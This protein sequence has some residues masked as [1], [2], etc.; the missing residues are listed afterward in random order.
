LLI[1][2]AVLVWRKNAM[3]LGRSDYQWRHEPIL[4]GWKEGGSGKHFY[5]GDRAKTTVWQIGRDAQASY[6]HPTQ[7]PVKL[8]SQLIDDYTDV[9][10]L[11]F[12]P[13]SGSGTT[14]I[15]AEQTGRIAVLIERQPSYVAVALERWSQ[16]MNETPVKL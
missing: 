9:G 5:C 7:K 10:E 14:L 4:Y 16:L 6:V 2:F 8:F 12:D 13:Y 1:I 3:T 15:A 11:I